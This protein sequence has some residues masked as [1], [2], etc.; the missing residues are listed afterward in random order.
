MKR[1]ILLCTVFLMLFTTTAYSTNSQNIE[2]EKQLGETNTELL[3]ELGYT[4]FD[5]DTFGEANSTARTI[6][7]KSISGIDLKKYAQLGY[8]KTQIEEFGTRDIEY[9]KNLEG[10]LIAVDKKYMKIESGKVSE[11]TKE[12]YDQSTQE[13]SNLAVVC[14]A[15]DVCSDTE[16][17]PNWLTL[18]TTISKVQNPRP[19]QYL[20]QHNF[21]WTK[22]P[23]YTFKDAFGVAH[24]VSMSPVQDS[25]YFK[26]T[27]DEYYSRNPIIGLGPW[28]ANGTKDTWYMSANDKT[29]GMGFEFDLYNDFAQLINGKVKKWEN[30]R[31]TMAYRVIRNNSTFTSADFS[32]H[33]IHTEQSFTGS[34]GL[35]IS[36]TGSFSISANITKSPATQTGVTFNY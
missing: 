32:G 28:H 34:I 7:N 29:G 22:K 30:H 23:Y 8:T 36:G 1:V 9:L 21:A 5:I 25:E 33:Y 3:L 16:P 19:Q 12:E 27:A 35:D 18:T 10:E 31:G 26:Y 2:V 6:T 17:S 11:I 14:D 4:Q 24:H 15:A 13:Y 20:V